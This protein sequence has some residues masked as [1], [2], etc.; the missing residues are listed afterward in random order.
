MAAANSNIQI[1]DLDFDSIKE[2]LKTFLR[3][4]DKFKDYD[5]EGSGLSV[6]LDVL[7]Y[8]T[9]YNSYYLNMVANEMFMD[10][11][12]L[13]SSV[14]SHAKLL[15]YTPRSSVSPSA[16]ITLQVNNVPVSSL[17]LNKFT[18]FQSEAIDGV[19]YTFVTKEA[20]TE[21]TSANTVIFNDLEIYQGEPISLNFS[22]NSQSNPKQVFTLPDA[23]ID[24][25]T[26]EV[27]VQ[28]SPTSISPVTYQL[29][30][31]FSTK[32]GESRIYYLQESL[33]GEYEIYFGDGILGKKLDDGNVIQVSYL[34]TN[35][36]S[37]FGANN[38]VLL[39]SIGY[40]NVVINP[41]SPSSGGS[42]KEDI[43]SIK[44]TAPKIYATQ[45]RAVTTD[46]YIALLSSNKIGYNFDD[47]TAWSGAENTP[48]NFGQ[49]FICAKPEGSYTLTQNQKERIINEVIKPNSVLTI[50]PVMVEPDYTYVQVIA[51]VVYDQRT[52]SLSSQQMKELVKATI[53][54]FGNITLNK[55]NSTF[56]MAD[57]LVAIKNSN[58]SIISNDCSIN[59]QKKF[60]P[61]TGQVDNYTLNYGVP[62][63]RAI[64][65]SGLYSDPSIQYYD[66]SSTL[67]EEVYLEEIPFNSSGLQEIKIINPG[68]GYTKN[69]IVTITGD[70]SGATARAL[71][72]N[73]YIYDIVLDNPGS[74]Y[75]QAI[76]T[77]TAAPDDTTGVTGSAY[78]VLQGQFGRIRSYYFVDGVKTIL[79]ENVGTID[80]LNGII[81]LVEFAPYE[82]NDPFGKLTL[83]IP[84]ETTIISSNKNRL[85]T[86]DPF[87]PNSIVVNVTAR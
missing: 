79:N 83:T 21:N 31:D 28:P 51:D 32:D 48:P 71:I 45:G 18:K 27:R 61:L 70:G 42:E 7:A 12:V 81:D 36:I 37:S 67:H 20:I 17:T 5:F 65:K 76:V 30:D 62:V 69:P 53:Q 43:E 78:A 44:Y 54:N 55:F 82:I 13:R 19:N 46:D 4:Q 23:N 57:L 72:K 58:S 38:F 86:I 22:Y 66:S 52:T 77:I 16:V 9:H 39:D 75:T 3:S 59:V 63:R 40:P 60:Y 8:N 33:T 34:I 41:K 74:N 2:N 14:I 64:Y 56:S 73:G 6:L 87:D 85:L 35:G 50:Q 80:Y 15:N 26:L 24:T 49:V 1:T 10:T 29:A 11:A 47:V 84:P 25:S 68:F